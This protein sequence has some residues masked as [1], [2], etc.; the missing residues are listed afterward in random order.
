[1]ADGAAY[2]TERDRVGPLLAAYGIREYRIR[3]VNDK[4]KKVVWEL[5]T[6]RGPRV[7]KGHRWTLGQVRFIAGAIEHCAARGVGVTGLERTLED[8]PFVWDGEFGYLLFHAVSGP[9]PRYEEPAEL[10]LIMETLADF[11]LRSRGYEPPPGAEAR[12]L[13]GTWPE[14]YRLHLGR[15]RAYLVEAS[16]GSD[17][18]RRL[19][20]EHLPRFIGRAEEALEALERSAYRDWVDQATTERG[21]CHQDFSAGNLRRQPDGTL[22]ILDLDGLTHELP[23]RDVRKILNKVMKKN[24]WE[25]DLALAMLGWYR[26][27][28]PLAP[29]QWEVILV[30]VAFPHLVDGVVDKYFRNR[31]PEWSDA[32]YLE[33]LKWMI[34]VEDSKA[35]AVA[36]LR[37]ALVEAGPAGGAPGR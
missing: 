19:A 5:T 29:E 14:T 28:H 35:E 27:A 37:R 11:H 9:S 8:E 34:D 17:P 22:A 26:Q 32:K 36:A 2:K 13:L 30:D 24:R 6:D 18:F 15:M 21:L 12:S 25:A 20:A 31:D 4:E 23:A 3:E 7:L 10:R 33:R 1:V 16:G